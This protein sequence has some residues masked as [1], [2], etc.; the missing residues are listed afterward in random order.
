MLTPPEIERVL[1][2]I[3]AALRKLAPY[4]YAAIVSQDENAAGRLRLKELPSSGNSGSAPK[5]ELP[6]DL[7]PAAWVLANRKLL[8][9][10][11]S[12]SVSLSAPPDQS[13]VEIKYGGWIP[14][15]RNGGAI[16][17]LFVGS[18]RDAQVEQRVT[19]LLAPS[20]PVCATL[21][22]ESLQDAADL[23]NHLS[24]EKAYLEEQLRAEWRFENVIGM[25][26]GFRD[27]M[28]R[29]R[30][31]G[32]AHETVLIVGEN[33]TEKELIA[34]LIHQIS[35]RHRRTFV[36]IN[37]SAYPS[38]VLAKKLFGY[39]KVGLGEEV[40]KRMGRLEL[41]HHSTLFLEEVSD[42]PI[43][44]QSRLAVAIRERG[45]PPSEGR[46]RVPLDIRLL[47]STSRDLS[48]MVNFG[49]FNRDLYQLLTVFPIE[50]LPLRK[51]LGDI[52]LL[53]DHFVG[54]FAKRLKKSITTIPQET[55]SALS[56][57]HWPG[58]L[59]ELESFIERAVMLTPAST[60]HAPLIEL[61]PLS[62]ENLQAAERKHILRVLRDSRG[63]IGGRAGAAH[64]LGVKRTTLNSKLKKL[65][66]QREARS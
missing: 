53:V 48:A 13:P 20:A 29:V 2:A 17:V 62:E 52:P 3:S 58:N 40:V 8:L 24:E 37:C 9:V 16:G 6:P 51:R 10:S 32:P 65:G 50:L 5:A 44:L 7:T 66:I 60:L 54:K 56:A 49:Q 12:D 57:G 63:V 27:V 35:P 41:A 30:K 42:L 14:V 46:P 59:K 61:E 36:K 28:E 45:L 22:T 11:G 23:T 15:T 39:E 43:E 25:S 33:G 34:R 55:M 18:Q 26:T 19:S 38:Q 21:E 64:K 31:V 47:A 4:D 1:P